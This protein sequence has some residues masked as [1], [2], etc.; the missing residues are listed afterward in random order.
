VKYVYICSLV[1]CLLLGGIIGHRLF[2]RTE[3]REV[4]TTVTKVQTVTKEVVRQADGT[5]IERVVTQTKDKVKTSP[6][7]PKPQYRVGALLPVASELKLPTVTVS[8]RAFGEV[9]LDAQYDPRHNEALIG[10]SVEF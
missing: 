8:R 2:P 7:P 9:W 3:L 6:Q 1:V 10:I 5:V 4:P